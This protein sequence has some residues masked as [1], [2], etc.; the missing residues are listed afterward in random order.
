MTRE[1]LIEK[2]PLP[3]TF[4]Q[5]DTD[6]GGVILSHNDQIMFRLSTDDDWAE[7]LDPV[8]YDNFTAEELKQRPVFN[9]GGEEESYAVLDHLLTQLNG[10][11]PVYP[12][13]VSLPMED[14]LRLY[15]AAMRSVMDGKAPERVAKRVLAACDRTIT[16]IAAAHRMKT[17]DY[18]EE[19]LIEDPDLAEILRANLGVPQ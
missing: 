8:H 10:E 12:H 18:K 4:E 6:G 17:G 19:V 2:Y 16:G 13:V 5:T 3:W 7:T 11:V 1:E 15:H 9:E 14:A